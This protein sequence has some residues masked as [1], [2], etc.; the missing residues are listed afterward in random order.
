MLLSS[1]IDL[2]LFAAIVWSAL[3][4][5]VARWAISGKVMERLVPCELQ[6]TSICYYSNMV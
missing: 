5:Q 4:I 6:Y 2:D 3:N 1:K